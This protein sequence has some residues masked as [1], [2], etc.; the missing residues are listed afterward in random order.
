M[1]NLVVRLPWNLAR[2]SDS[3]QLT[4]VGVSRIRRYPDICVQTTQILGYD[5][6]NRVD[7]GPRR[8]GLGIFTQI[9]WSPTISKSL[10][11][12]DIP[13]EILALRTEFLSWNHERRA[14]MKVVMTTATTATFTIDRFN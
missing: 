3:T 2:R 12:R 10:F 7:V 1:G 11:W 13:T 14:S 8:R 9:L 5:P 4:V 6:P